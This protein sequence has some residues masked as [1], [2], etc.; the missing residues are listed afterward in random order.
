[1]KAKLVSVAKSIWAA[2][3]NDPEAKKAARFVLVLAVITA[4]KAF[5]VDSA[6]IDQLSSSLGL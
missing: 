3:V 1:M 6:V 5:G 2:E 4:L